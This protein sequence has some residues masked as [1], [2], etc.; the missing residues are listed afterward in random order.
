[1]SARRIARVHGHMYAHV[2][3]SLQATC[4]PQAVIGVRASTSWRHQAGSSWYA[5]TLSRRTATKTL[6]RIKE[7][8]SMKDT[9]KK[10]EMNTDEPP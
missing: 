10:D 5:N 4:R 8:T 2:H 1:M 9:K 7:L 6:K 3:K